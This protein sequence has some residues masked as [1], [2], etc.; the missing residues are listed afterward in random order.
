MPLTDKEGLRQTDH[1]PLNNPDHS[2]E[3]NALRSAVVVPL[4]HSTT[5]RVTVAIVA[6][7]LPVANYSPSTPIA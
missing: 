1:D 6:I 2:A 5:R 4:C 7:K 3:L